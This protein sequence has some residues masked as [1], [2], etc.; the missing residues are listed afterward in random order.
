MPVLLESIIGDKQPK[1]I[2]EVWNHT[3][4]SLAGLVELELQQI[5]KVLLH[6]NGKLDESII[7]ANVYPI[8]LYKGSQAIKQLITKKAIGSIEL[9]LAFGSVKQINRVMAERQQKQ[10]ILVPDIIREEKKVVLPYD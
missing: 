1:L 6:S 3:F 10:P 7:T 5:P 4:Q 8:F 2:V 9:S